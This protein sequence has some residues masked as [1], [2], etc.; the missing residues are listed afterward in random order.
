MLH[1]CLIGCGRVAKSHMEGALQIKDKL[2]VVAVVD[3]V[4]ENAEAFCRDYGAKA[5][6]RSFEEA[7]QAV[8]FEAVDICLPNHLHC[9]YTVKAAE[10][11]KHVL[12][13]KPMA[14]TVEECETMIAAAEANGV[15]LMIGQSRRYFDAV[16][17]SKEMIAAGEIGK[18]VS[19]SANLYAYLEKAPTPWWNK[20]ETAGGLMI[21]IWGSHIID[22]CLWVFD[23]LPQRVYCETYS[24]NPSWEGEDEV[25]LTLGFSEGR[26][27]A[28]R[29][30]WNTKLKDEAWNGEGKMLSSADAVYER[31][32][33][34]TEKSLYLND[35]TELRCNGRTIVEDDGKLT[36][37][38][39]QYL[40][41][42]A[43]VEEDREPLTS[44][45]RIL[46]VIKVQDAAL[47]SARVHQVV[48]LQEG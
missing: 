21:P 8:E 29:M 36:N 33:Q 26:F 24:V 40:E 10:A 13:E 37:F 35:E 41:F 1:I 44:G 23:E 22:Y 42:V 28:I 15:K 9:E 20:K 19:V 32:I 14:N 30:S 34:G 48:T 6:F 39:R 46:N 11:K 12:I 27:G 17:H 5:A 7:C 18:L 2:E 16:I 47:E 43:S 31:Y 45:K 38:A 3:P 4:I 25:M